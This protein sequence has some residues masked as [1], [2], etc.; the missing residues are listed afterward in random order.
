M[1]VS[2]E[3]RFAGCFPRIPLGT[4]GTNLTEEKLIKELEELHDGIDLRLSI[5]SP[6]CYSFSSH[7]A[8]RLSPKYELPDA[9][10]VVFPDYGIQNSEIRDQKVLN[11]EARI[12][13][14]LSDCGYL[15]LENGQDGYG[16]IKGTG[17][18][19]GTSS[20]PSDVVGDHNIFFEA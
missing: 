17:K 12:T 15:V 3:N 8:N 6:K 14:F 18:R 11:A 10:I 5:S 1:K 13:R 19:R 2:L 20:S 9:N 7:K 16:Y 4:P